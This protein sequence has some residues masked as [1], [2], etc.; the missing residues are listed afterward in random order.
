M[1]YK[2]TPAVKAALGY[3][4]YFE[5]RSFHETDIIAYIKKVPNTSWFLISSIE[6][7]EVFASLYN[8]LLVVIFFIFTLILSCVISFGYILKQQK[9]QYSEE[10]ANLIELNLFQKNALIEELEASESKLRDQND[11]I[12]QSL[13]QK[14]ALIEELEASQSKLREQNEIIE[15]NLFQKN[16]LLEQLSES[17]IKLKETIAS[18][19]KFF[20]IISHD[21]RSPFSGLLGLSDI[22]VKEAN[23]L[24]KEELL[25]LA[26]GINQSA[27]SLFKL[28]ND[29]LQWSRTQTNSIPYETEELDLSE[30]CF[31]TIFSLKNVANN[32]NID[33]IQKI[34]PNTVVIGDRNMLSAIFRNLISNAIKFTDEAGAI[35]I[36]IYKGEELDPTRTCIYVKDNGVGIKKETIEKLFRIDKNITTLGTAKERGTGL[37]LIMCKEFVEKHGGKI[38]VESEDGQGSTFYF[39]V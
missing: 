27:N 2:E 11:I 6:K 36:G 7:S 13:F 15:L 28:L 1:R 20:S 3:V 22:I 29:L 10:K 26:G 39:T 32:K 38:W 12:E 17:E 35:E 19:D 24:T 9:L 21:L 8:E 33:L 5:G 16:A 14:N 23:E 25:E 30:I 18:K 37:G 31:N 4:G 34:D